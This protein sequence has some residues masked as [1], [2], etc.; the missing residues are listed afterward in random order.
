MSFFL[1]SEKLLAEQLLKVL[2]YLFYEDGSKI[3]EIIERLGLMVEKV[4]G[5][6]G[7]GDH[8]MGNEFDGLN[9]FSGTCG[10]KPVARV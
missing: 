3:L 4:W 5:F 2:R 8:D 1:I 9:D 7:D 10:E 6:W